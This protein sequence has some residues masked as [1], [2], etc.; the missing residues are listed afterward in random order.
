MFDRFYLGLK[1]R[2][3]IDG[4]RFDMSRYDKNSEKYVI[5]MH[6]KNVW[7]NQW[8][9]DPRNKC[10]QASYYDPSAQYIKSW[11]SFKRKIGLTLYYSFRKLGHLAKECLGRRPG[12]LCC[13]VMNH[14][15][16]DFPR[17]IAKLE[18]MNMR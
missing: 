2:V 1:T 18:E 9:Q 6:R 15:V 12:C 8:M 14:E 10:L 16:L 7:T 5:P 3:L 4:R 17:M 11:E 13:K